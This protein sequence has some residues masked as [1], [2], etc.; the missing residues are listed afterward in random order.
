MSNM[1]KLTIRQQSDVIWGHT[2][3]FVVNAVSHT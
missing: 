1:L 3:E 2:S